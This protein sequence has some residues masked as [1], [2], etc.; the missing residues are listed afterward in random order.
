MP[1]ATTATPAGTL[2]K[3]TGPIGSV[4]RAWV[5]IQISLQSMRGI[6][7]CAL[8]VFPATIAS[9]SCRIPVSL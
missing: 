9:G 7:P 6:V 3:V 5:V 8:I 4:S 1:S 2:V